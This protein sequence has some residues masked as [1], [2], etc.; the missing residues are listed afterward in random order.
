M[1]RRSMLK[2]HG[3]HYYNG[4]RASRG[5]RLMNKLHKGI[6]P[7]RTIEETFKKI[8]DSNGRKISNN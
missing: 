1:S 8:G 3:C 7:S 4:K 5:S 6:E 2:T